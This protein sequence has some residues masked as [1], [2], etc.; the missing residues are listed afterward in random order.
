MLHTHIYSI[1]R[2][3][4]FVTQILEKLLDREDQKKDQPT[5]TTIRVTRVTALA[6]GEN[7]VATGQSPGIVNTLTSN[8]HVIVEFETDTSRGIDVPVDGIPVLAVDNAALA[9]AVLVP[10]PTEGPGRFAFDFIP[11]LDAV[12]PVAVTVTADGRMGADVKTITRL[13]LFDILPLE[14]DLINV[15][16]NAPQDKAVVPPAAVLVTLSDGQIVPVGS[17]ATLNGVTGVVMADGSVVPPAGGGTVTPP[18]TPGI[19][20]SQTPVSGV[21]LNLNG[22]LSAGGVATLA[23]AQQVVLTY[24]NE[25]AARTL[26]LSGTDTTGAT[27]GETLSVP[28]GAAGTA[29]STLSYNSITSAV[30]AGGDW[31]APATLG[32]VAAPPVVAAAARRV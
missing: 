7:P 14:A 11:A 8:Q 27:I 12:G 2:K 5:P 1:E 19:A 18:A 21:A 32:T 25:V 30:P 10:A 24:G 4:D 16:V 29:Q 15:Q 3:L 6:K 23:S 26:V 28:A 17:T 13:I 9:T 22:A 20:L 31:T